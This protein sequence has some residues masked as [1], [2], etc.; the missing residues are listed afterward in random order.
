MLGHPRCDLG[1]AG[2][3]QRPGHLAIE[4]QVGSDPTAQA[5]PGLVVADHGN[6]SAS[7]SMKLPASVAQYGA[8]S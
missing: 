4:R 3:R 8:A 1:P 2:R 6:R 7:R 5:A